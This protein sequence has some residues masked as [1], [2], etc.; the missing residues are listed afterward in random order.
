MFDLWHKWAGD[1][2]VDSVGDLLSSTDS[3]TID[4][5]I[6]RRL[7]T[8]PGGYLW[9]LSYG[10]GLAGFV[11]T[12]A[13]LPELEGVI[14]SQMQQESLVAQTPE[15]T[16]KIDISN[17]ATGMVS[18]TITFTESSTGRITTTTVTPA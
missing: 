9:N 12:P 11:G 1:L 8:N 16:V 2:A 4:Q 13:Q 7:L 6:Y 3:Q 17:I 5:R 10:G 18:A 15:P 14:R